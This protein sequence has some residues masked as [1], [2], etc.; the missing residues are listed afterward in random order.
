MTKSGLIEAVVAQMPH[1]S[2]RDAEVIVNTMFDQMTEALVC[3]DRIE[4][5]GF[6]SFSVRHRRARTGRNPKTGGLISV[7]EKRVP[8]FTVGHSLK[9][10]VNR[11]GGY[12]SQG[13][14][15]PTEDGLGDGSPNQADS[16]A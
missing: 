15:P 12:A 8:F 11:G 2:Q 1:L 7:P 16:S 3:G 4:I 6:G 5:R 9:E 14:T 13:T 10:R